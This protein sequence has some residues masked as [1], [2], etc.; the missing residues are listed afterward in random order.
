MELN[1]KQNI[2]N[3]IKEKYANLSEFFIEMTR[4]AYPDY[5]PYEY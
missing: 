5:N 1:R 4:I 2:E 3:K